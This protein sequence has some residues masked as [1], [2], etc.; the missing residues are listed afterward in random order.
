[1]SLQKYQV[2]DET[3]QVSYHYLLLCFFQM[4]MQLLR[5]SNQMGRCYLPGTSVYQAVTFRIS[6]LRIVSYYRG[7]SVY[8]C[9]H[10]YLFQKR[11]Y[12]AQVCIGFSESSVFF[13]T[14]KPI[15][16][17][18]F[19]SLPLLPPDL[20]SNPTHFVAIKGSSRY[21]LFLLVVKY[22]EF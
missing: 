11:I 8:I 19:S 22:L 2:H 5:S 20:P 7:T 6:C 12:C 3:S 13:L 4:E 17:R 9:L 1:M 21:L 16:Q 18:L 15:D 14:Y 10:F